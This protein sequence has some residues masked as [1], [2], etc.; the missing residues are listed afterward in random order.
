MEVG[1]KKR[2]RQDEMER[3]GGDGEL[4]RGRRDSATGMG[5]RDTV[6]FVSSFPSLASQIPTQLCYWSKRAYTYVETTNVTK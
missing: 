4:G 3:E 6:V 2:E 1:S 5:M